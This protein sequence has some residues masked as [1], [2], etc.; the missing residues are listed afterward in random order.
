MGTTVWPDEDPERAE[1]TLL[2]MRGLEGAYGE[3]EPE[4]SLDMIK[5]PLDAE[6]P[7]CQR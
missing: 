7:P 6:E 2:A 4:H 1:W 5:L 3:D